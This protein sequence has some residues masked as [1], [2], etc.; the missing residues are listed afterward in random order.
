MHTIDHIVLVDNNSSR[1]SSL[2]KSIKEN[3][4]AQS[5]KT[6]LNGGHALL[7]LEHISEKIENS[8]VLILLNIHTPM[9]NGF[10]FIESFKDLK[11]VK[12]NNILIAVIT[13]NL[14]QNEVDKIKLMGISDFVSTQISLDNLHSIIDTKFQPKVQSPKKGK[15]KVD[16]P[17]LTGSVTNQ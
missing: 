9:V 1:T 17:N 14:N 5:T 16:V 3:G 11:T 4:L 15:R 12:K 8:R 6:T 2:E 10:E 7:Y 13:D